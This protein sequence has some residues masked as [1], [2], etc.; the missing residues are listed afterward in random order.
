VLLALQASLAHLA[1]DPNTRRD[2]A[3]FRAAL[4]TGDPPAPLRGA[5]ATAV[6]CHAR[7]P[8]GALQGFGPSPVECLADLLLLA[9]P[10]TVLD[11]VRCAG[12]A[13]LDALDFV[14]PGDPAF[15]AALTRFAGPAIAADLP[16]P[17]ERPNPWLLPQMSH[18]RSQALRRARDL[19][20]H[21]AAP[22]SLSA[23]DP[24]PAPAPRAETRHEPPTDSAA[25][26]QAP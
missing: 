23:P 4:L 16:A 7:G 11:E 9:C 13:S 26:R 10:P 25:D 14:A 24:P 2:A 1:R 21:F 17:P 5:G 12:E 18:I 3:P 8:A 20:H 15:A 22:L 19:T 6:I